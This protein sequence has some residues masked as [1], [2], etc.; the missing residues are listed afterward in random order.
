MEPSSVQSEFILTIQKLKKRF[1]E[2]V[3]CG[4]NRAEKSREAKRSGIWGLLLSGSKTVGRKRHKL[5]GFFFQFRAR[6]S[7]DRRQGR[8]PPFAT[9]KP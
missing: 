5:G 7:S 6:I 1:S 4:E 3:I 9:Q 8:V 2:E